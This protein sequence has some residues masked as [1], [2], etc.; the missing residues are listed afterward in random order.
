MYE[1]FTSVPARTVI[2]G[3]IGLACGTVIAENVIQLRHPEVNNEEKPRW[4]TVLYLVLSIA[5]IV[6]LLVV[7]QFGNMENPGITQ[8]TVIIACTFGAGIG[9][10]EFK[11]ENNSQQDNNITNSETNE[12]S[13]PVSDKPNT[14]TNI[15]FSPSYGYSANSSFA[16]ALP[17][18]IDRNYL[19]SP[20]TFQYSAEFYCRL[21]EASYSKV[22]DNYAS[23]TMFLH[24]DG[25]FDFMCVGEERVISLYPKSAE[26]IGSTYSGRDSDYI[27]PFFTMHFTQ[28]FVNGTKNSDAPS[29]TISFD[30]TPECIT[31]KVE[32]NI[33]GML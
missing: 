26:Y 15:A 18:N 12:L 19:P 33:G 11:K 23:V 8:V 21:F 10:F 30:E 3:L 32:W 6:L 31:I 5:A 2:W 17:D 29:A 4:K 7:P 13:N 22:Y 1:F 27:V 14:Q 24:R 28:S 20:N 9:Y 25:K 16:S